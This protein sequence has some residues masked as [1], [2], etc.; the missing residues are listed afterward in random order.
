MQELTIIVAGASCLSWLWLLLFRHKF[1]KADQRLEN[2]SINLENWP[3]VA[4][5]VPARNEAKVI[6]RTIN[7]L[8]NQDYPGKFSI[9]LVDDHS[10]DDTIIHASKAANADLIKIVKAP[11][12]PRGWTGK[13]S[14]LAHGVNE[15]KRDTPEHKYILFTDADIKHSSS[16]LRNLVLKAETEQCDLVSLMVRL[17][18]RSIWEL[19]LIPAFVF[20]FQK[21]YPFNAVNDIRT[22]FAAAAGGVIL[23]RTKSLSNCGGITAI[24]NALIDDC[25]L[26]ALIKKHNGRL[27]IG[28]AEDIKSIRPYCGLK[29]IWH[30]I[31]RN[32]YTQL[33][34]SPLKLLGVVAGMAIIYL[35][36]PLI[37]ISFIVHKYAASSFL[38]L[39]TWVLMSYAY[40]PTVTYY[41][42]TR[43]W[44]LS[45]P[46]AAILYILMT[47]NS[48]VHHWQNKGRKWK[49][50]IY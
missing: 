34:Y 28:L 42:I 39:I 37:L 3:G 12:L 43:L 25:A 15:A 36:S 5:I 7:F 40:L 18:C 45:L 14:A 50:R 44:V 19:I 21:L 29:D 20:F 27:W 46:I 8:T 4:I 47:I 38:A 17:H 26:A 13:L 9:I 6:G 33:E 24:K 23:V 49:G 22:S 1:W 41:R 11:P 16:S 10:N 32:A 31:A 35:P 2:F 30:M 48:A